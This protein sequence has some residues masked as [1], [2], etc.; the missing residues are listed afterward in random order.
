MRNTSEENALKIFNIDF[1][2]ILEPTWVDFGLQVGAQKTDSNDLFSKLRPRGV[3]ERPKSAP[4]T[5]QERPRVP[6][7]R[8]KGTQERPKSSPRV[9][10]ST[11]R[12]SLERPRGSQERPRVRKFRNMLQTG[13]SELQ[14]FGRPQILEHISIPTIERDV[15]IKL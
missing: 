6:Q 12:A 9:P 13:R 7:E 10:K 11:P 4:S 3:Q 8:P 14:T 5:S 2:R 1:L 15:N